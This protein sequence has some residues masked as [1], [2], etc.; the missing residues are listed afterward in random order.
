MPDH[1]V[2]TPEKI[3]GAAV[4]LQDPGTTMEFTLWKEALEALRS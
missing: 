4:M 2:V 3:I 1:G